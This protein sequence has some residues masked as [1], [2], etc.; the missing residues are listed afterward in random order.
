MFILSCGI[1]FFWLVNA[2]FCC[3]RFSFFHAKPRDWFGETSPKWPILCPVGRKT[4]RYDT[5]RY[6][7]CAQKPRWA[8]LIY[9]TEPTTKKWKTEKL[10]SWPKNGYTQKYQSTVRGIHVV[11]SEGEKE[12]YSGEDLQKRNNSVYQ[13]IDHCCCLCFNLSINIRLLRN[14][15]MQANNS[16]QKGNTVS[17]KKACLDD[18]PKNW[19]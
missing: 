19:A 11:R 10:K 6:L 8:S 1:H 12:G 3:V 14:D 13:S 2:W 9:R 15:K 17:K 5:R 4:I 18:K 16:K 7:T